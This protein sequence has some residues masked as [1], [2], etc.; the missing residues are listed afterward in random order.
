[1]K[2]DDFLYTLLNTRGEYSGN[3]GHAISVSSGAWHLAATYVTASP[4]VS[5][6]VMLCQVFAAASC[7][8]GL[9]GLSAPQH[10]AWAS[11]NGSRFSLPDIR[12]LFGCLGLWLCWMT[13]CCPERLDAEGGT[14]TCCVSCRWQWAGCLKAPGE[15]DPAGTVMSIVWNVWQCWFRDRSCGFTWW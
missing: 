15:S 7:C 3:W 2:Y 4:S 8:C 13:G 9:W 11:S 14:F 6:P 12:F 5:Y 10:S 1:M